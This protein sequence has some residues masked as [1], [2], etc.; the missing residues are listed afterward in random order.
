MTDREFHDAVLTQGRIP[1]EMIRAA[2]T[3]QELRRD[4]KSGWRFY[5]EAPAAGTGR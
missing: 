3:R 5:G 2:L 1:V 4:F